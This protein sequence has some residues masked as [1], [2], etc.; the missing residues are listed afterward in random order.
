MRFVDPEGNAIWRA[1][2]GYINGYRAKELA[3]QQMRNAL[4]GLD[5]Q[6]DFVR[7]N[8]SLRDMWEDFKDFLNG[9]TYAHGSF[10]S[11]MALRFGN[12]IRYR[13]T[14]FRSEF[15][16]DTRYS[17]KQLSNKPDV[18]LLGQ[19]A[20][21]IDILTVSFQT[22]DNTKNDG[23]RYTNT[24]DEIIKLLEGT[25]KSLEMFITKK[26]LI[27]G[28]REWVEEEKTYYIE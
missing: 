12:T 18:K 13:N 19:N 2:E 17:F 22:N 7:K 14:G 15:F 5:A 23:I 28:D 8:N 20:K 25:G 9:T 27:D 21:G 24:V 16:I 3:Y 1:G 26:T 6:I 11:D 4:R 10:V